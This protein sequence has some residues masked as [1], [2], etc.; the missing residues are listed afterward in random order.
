M[1]NDKYRILSTRH[2]TDSSVAVAGE[3]GI[4][5]DVQDFIQIKPLLNEALLGEEHMAQIFRPEAV[6]VFTSANAARILAKYYLHQDDTFY[7]IS[8][9]NICCI[10]GSTRKAVENVFTDC[11]ILAESPYGSELAKAIIQIGNI[12]SVNFFC[13]NIRRNE[14]PDALQKAGIEVKEFVI[15][16]NIPAPAVTADDYDGVLFF[17]PSAVKSYLS[18]NRLNSKTVCFAIGRTTATELREHTDNKIIMSTDISEES[19][20]QTAIFYFNN[21]NCYE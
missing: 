20:V 6:H 11:K 19:M 5:I 1:L 14:L 21:I 4:H 7:V 10:S 2:L 9:P 12:T 18:A 3:S 16:E 15:Y 17:S 8:E 13:G